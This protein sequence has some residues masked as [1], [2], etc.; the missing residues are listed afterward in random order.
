MSTIGWR[1]AACGTTVDIAVSH[2]WRCPR[3]TA[4]D[5]HHV[6]HPVTDL[7]PLRPLDHDNPFVAFDPVLAWSAHAAVHGMVLDDRVALVEDLDARVRA[8]D[9]RGAGFHPTPLTR[10][11]ALS[12]AL[13]FDAG[14][15]GGVWIKDETGNV[16]GSHK[17]RHL[18]TV[19][20]HLL[21][22]ERL[23]LA[24]SVGSGSGTAG[25]PRLAIASC[26]NAALAAATLAAA[27]EWPLRVFVPP[28]ADPWVLAELRRLDTEVVVCPRRPDD[29]PGDPCLH[30]FRDA[31]ASGAVPFSVQGPDDALCL[32]GGRTLG[33][34]IL[35]ALGPRLDRWFVQVG[36]G[37]FGSCLALAAR[38]AGLHPRL[39]AVQAEGCAPLPRAWQ[40]WRSGARRWD[41]VMW[42]W[43]TEPHSAASGILDDET[44]D[45]LGIIEGIEE[46]NGSAV[47]V[48]EALV[49]E[50]GELTR[51]TTTIDASP[52]GTAGLAGLLAM[53]SEVADDEQVVVVFSGRRWTPAPR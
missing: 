51:R 20:L 49:V 37:A 19:M 28:S 16:A 46:S 44:Y 18:A 11:D 45:W 9:A 30:R 6:L 1:C 22:C 14:A 25:R 34:E 7:A 13:G 33:W 24:G 5:R 15:G 42:P 36:G 26:G 29:L 10:A 50:A 47:V 17:G 43:E 38:S 8:V 53:R 39:F 23:G 35:L 3:A 40:R 31:V 48:P 32:D 52:T 21:A 4:A 41:D 27:V 2:P 12:D